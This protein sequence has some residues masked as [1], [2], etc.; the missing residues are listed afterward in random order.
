[1]PGEIG[2][3]GHSNHELGEFRGR[4]AASAIGRVADVR[5][6]PGS[7]RHPRF[8]REALDAAPGRAGSALGTAATS[9]ADGTRGCPGRPTRPGGSRRTTPAP[10]PGPR[11]RS[12][13]RWT[14]ERRRRARPDG[15]P[16]LQG[17]PLA[18]P[19]PADRRRAEHPGLG[20]PRQHRAAQ[21]RATRP[22]RFRLGPRRSADVPR[23]AAA[24]RRLRPS[25]RSGPGR[26]AAAETNTRRIGLAIANGRKPTASC[27]R[28]FSSARS[29]PDDALCSRHFGGQ[30]NPGSISRPGDDEPNLFAW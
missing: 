13:R 7:R 25:P 9:A 22:G 24:P 26:T 4:L 27:D 16:R 1:M 10:A 11:R 30:A 8:N 3:I 19:S 18:V 12:P 28:Q 21:G 17:D 2:T 6:F 20:R 5:R 14:S 23:R 15:D 29:A